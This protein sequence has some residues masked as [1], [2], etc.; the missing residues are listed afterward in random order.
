MYNHTKDSMLVNL[1]L[2][3]S[4]HLRRA[5]DSQTT[6]S[7]DLQVEKVTGIDMDLWKVFNYAFIYYKDTSKTS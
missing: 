6:K 5:L 7:I 1:S 4:L 3:V 2:A